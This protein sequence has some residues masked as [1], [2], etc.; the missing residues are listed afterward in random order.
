[1]PRYTVQYDNR[2]GSYGV[3]D[4]YA[5]RFVGHAGTEHGARALRRRFRDNTE[6]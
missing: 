4:R 3:W 6:G 1:M 2:I 5:C